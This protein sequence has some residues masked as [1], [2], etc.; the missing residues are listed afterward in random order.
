MLLTPLRPGQLE[1]E[2]WR[3]RSNTTAHHYYSNRLHQPHWAILY[4]STLFLPSHRPK[5]PLLV[6]TRFF[7][8][9]VGLFSEAKKSL[10]FIMGNVRRLTSIWRNFSKCYVVNG[11]QTL[12]FSKIDKHFFGHRRTLFVKF[13]D[14]RFFLLHKRRR[15]LFSL[16]WDLGSMV[17]KLKLKGTLNLLHS[18]CN[19]FA[20]VRIYTVVYNILLSTVTIGNIK[21]EIAVCLL[22][23]LS[24]LWHYL[25]PLNKG[26]AAPK[27]TPLGL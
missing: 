3:N 15:T 20:S 2:L 22:L 26:P 10:Y 18:T 9:A 4:C 11:R 19:F 24:L 27:A 14:R 23:S 6:P 12:F 21:Q 7:R 5:R 13:V 1:G 8:Y 25:W 17:A 16:Q